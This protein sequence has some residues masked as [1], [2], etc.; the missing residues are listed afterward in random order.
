MVEIR[1]SL[2][3][4]MLF[5]VYEASLFGLYRGLAGVPWKHFLVT[6]FG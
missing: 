4:W 1:F 5:F 2:R 6:F 3:G